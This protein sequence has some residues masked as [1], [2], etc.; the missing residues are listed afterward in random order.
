M[1]PPRR[2]AG[3]ALLVAAAVAIVWFAAC[4]PQ[5]RAVRA[6]AHTAEPVAKLQP[7]VVAAPVAPRADVPRRYRG[8]V[9]R[10]RV[11]Y[12]PERMLALTFDDGPDPQVTPVVLA[13]LKRHEARAT[14][15]VLGRNV[16]RWPELVKQA[17]GEGHAVGSHAY[18]HP[19]R[20]SPAEARRQLAETADLIEQATGDRPTLFRPPYGITTGNLCET[21][22]GEDYTAVLWTISSADSRP[23]S[24]VTI[25]Q[26][27]IHTPNPGDIVLMHD[28]AGH[29]ATAKALEQIL[30]ELGATGFRFVTLPELLAAWDRWLGEQQL[31]E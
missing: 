16:R 21:A 17:A 20:C 12:F 10:K 13:T 19:E 31:T 4:R 3:N 18:S 28:G 8:Q 26:N 29:A 14:F 24:A 5:P 11:R 15:F 1:T 22:L 6:R 25:A 2:W 30:T 7:P 9:V 23:I 27:V